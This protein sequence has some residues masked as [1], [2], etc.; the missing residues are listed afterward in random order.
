LSSSTGQ[1]GVKL[2]KVKDKESILK[3]LRAKCQ[4]AFKGNPIRP[5]ADF[6][7]ETLQAMRDYNDVFQLLKESNPDYYIQQ[8][9]PSET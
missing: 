1:F 8:E 2:P 9:C 5:T 7:A 6:S 4:V 3:A